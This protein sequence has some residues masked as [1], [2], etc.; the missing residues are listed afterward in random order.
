MKTTLAAAAGVLLFAPLFAFAQSLA[1][2]QSVEPVNVLDG[3]STTVATLSVP[4]AGIQANE[5]AILINDNDPQS[6]DVAN[7][8]QL[9]RGIPS[10]NM[11]HLRFNGNPNN[12]GNESGV[13]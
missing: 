8:Y 12:H 7:Y 9:K 3:N 5:I 2:A 11:I 13:F 1:F 6:V 10:Q 4:R